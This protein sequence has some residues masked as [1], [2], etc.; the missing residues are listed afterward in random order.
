MRWEYAFTTPADANAAQE[1]VAAEEWRDLRP[2]RALDSALQEPPEGK[3]SHRQ[4]V[5]EVWI[6]R[7]RS[8]AKQAVDWVSRETGTMAVLI[9]DSGSPKWAMGDPIFVRDRPY[10]VLCPVASRVQ[11][12][13]YKLH[14]MVLLAANEA[15]RQL[16]AEQMGPSQRIKVV[17]EESPGPQDG[18]Q[19]APLPGWHLG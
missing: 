14:S 17:G 7:Q 9:A 15:H 5:S 1:E 2:E 19:R 10:A 3:E 12:L 11:A 13:R 4:P 18:H 6:A 16:L 8:L